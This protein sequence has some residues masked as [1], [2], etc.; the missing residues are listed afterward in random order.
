VAFGGYGG[1]GVLAGLPLLSVGEHPLP[2]AANGVVVAAAAATFTAASPGRSARRR[3]AWSWSAAVLTALVAFGS[4][5]DAF[6]L[7]VGQGVDSTP[8]A[9][10]HGAGLVG[11]LLVLATTSAGTRSGAAPGRPCGTA[12]PRSVRRTAYAGVLGLAPYVAMKQTWAWGGTFAG[13]SGDDMLVTARRNGAS[14][15][16]LDLERVGVDVTVL[17][18]AAGSVLL[19]LLVRTPGRLP[20]WLLLAP[21]ALGA[22]TLVPYGCLGLGYVAAGTAGLVQFPRGDFPSAQDALLVSWIGLTA[23]CLHGV[24]LAVAGASYWR[25]T[26]ATP[27]AASPRPAATCRR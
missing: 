8:T 13:M 15:L 11:L 24:A 21:A 23:F 25:R 6:T 17:A 5:M 19:L 9:L 7:V 1:Y 4:L 2:L 3:R 27:A 18:G 16:W 26:S 14:R 22:S 12:A 10:T 20:R